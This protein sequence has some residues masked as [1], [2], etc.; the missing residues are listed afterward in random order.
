[1]FVKIL[2]GSDFMS[3]RNTGL[4]FRSMLLTLS[5]IAL[6]LIGYLSAKYFFG[7]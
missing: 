4:F 5:A 1:M 6:I 2:L 3:N 7:G